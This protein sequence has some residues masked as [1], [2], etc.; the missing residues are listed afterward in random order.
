MTAITN[1]AVPDLGRRHGLVS[2]LLLGGLLLLRFPFLIA[3]DMLLARES[4]YRTASVAIFAGDHG[5]HAQGVTPWPQEVTGQMVA[6]FLAGGAAINVLARH[7]GAEVCVVDVGVA[8]DIPDGTSATGGPGLVRRGD[9][10]A[11]LGE[12]TLGHLGKLAERHVGDD[13]DFSHC[14]PVLS[15]TLPDKWRA[16]RFRQMLFHQS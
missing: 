3:A 8:A 4:D 12:L 14:S 6:N 11:Q 13:D 16:G 10:R 15:T 5:V 9:F 1:S 7:A 2:L